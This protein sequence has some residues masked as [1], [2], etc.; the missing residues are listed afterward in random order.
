MQRKIKTFVQRHINPYNRG[1][2]HTN[3]AKEADVKL[4]QASYASS[5]IHRYEEGRT[6]GGDG[7]GSVPPDYVALGTD[8]AKLSATF[9]KW[10]EKRTFERATVEDFVSGWPSSEIPL[11]ASE[12]YSS[13]NEHNRV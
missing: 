7:S 11:P 3:P 4:L 1:S 5:H 6:F 12:H 2:K 13:D 10:A 8:Y 9:T